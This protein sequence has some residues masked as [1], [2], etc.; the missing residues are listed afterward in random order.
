MRGKILGFANG[1]G[2]IAG[3]GDKRYTF[4]LEGWRD[5]SPPRRGQSVDFVAGDD[6]TADEIYPAL[7]AF[8]GALGSEGAKAGAELSGLLEGVKAN[9]AARGIVARM[10]AYPQAVLAIILL[11]A[12][13]S[14][15]YARIPIAQINGP[16]PSGELAPDEVTLAELN[17]ALSPAREGF[18]KTLD[19]LTY[20][21]D[22]MRSIQG[23]S[24][25]SST[26]IRDIEKIQSRI[27]IFVWFINASIIFWMIPILVIGLIYSSWKGRT[28]ATGFLV[29]SLG[30][31]AIFSG[32]YLKIL[33]W[34][35]IAG[36]P[37]AMRPRFR[38]S[39]ERA[40]E[41]HL[42]GWIIVAIGIA[43]LALPFIRR[44]KELQAG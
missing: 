33:E 10:R 9:D 26:R 34:R 44:R 19:K 43:L 40:Y 7:G 30:V 5:Q 18:G 42:G 2:A 35:I 3:E 14:M 41:L 25:Y 39:I 29:A 32:V 8:T 28:M 17:D 6:G 23:P 13:F 38:L 4:S 27:R 37:E 31:L 21:I 22:T 15:T 20:S 16:Q 12:F 24:D 36:I 11:F 1:R